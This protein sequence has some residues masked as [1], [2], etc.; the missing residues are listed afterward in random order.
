M[1]DNEKLERIFRDRCK[2]CQYYKIKTKGWCYM[3][4]DF[5][6]HCKDYIYEM[7]AADVHHALTGE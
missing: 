5:V 2:C 4:Q 6:L 7:S 3:H 1:T